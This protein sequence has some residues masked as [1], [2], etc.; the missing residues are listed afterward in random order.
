M[1]IPGMLKLPSDKFKM[2][3]ESWCFLAVVSQP[4]GIK[5]DIKDIWHEKLSTEEIAKAAKLRSW[6]GET[7]SMKFSGSNMPPLILQG[8]CAAIGGE[9]EFGELSRRAEFLGDI[10]SRSGFGDPSHSLEE[11]WQS[12]QELAIWN[13]F[14]NAQDVQIVIEASAGLDDDVSIAGVLGFFEF[15]VGELYYFV[16][17]DAPVE[18]QSTGQNG[19]VLNWGT[20]VVRDC[21]VDHDSEKVRSA[22]QGAH[23]VEASSRGD[24]W[25]DLGDL[26]L[27]LGI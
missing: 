17:F 20:R 24:D 22:G 23:E 10:Q 6:G 21:Y 5:I 1:K 12:L 25:L 2:V 16:V 27:I 8:Q 19:M 3:V 7:M 4:E 11:L 26:R 9:A 18:V 15:Q 14:L 13:S